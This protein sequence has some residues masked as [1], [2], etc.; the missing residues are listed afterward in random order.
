MA[1]GGSAGQVKRGFR[2]GEVARLTGLTRRQL[3]YWDRTGF[4]R[5]SL[6]P[7]GGRGASR[8]Y[9]FEDIVVLRVVR[10]LL[11]AGMKVR[12]LRQCV[13]Y[14]RCN[15]AGEG[16]AAVCLLFLGGKPLLVPRGSTY[17]VDVLR[18]GQLVWMLDLQGV[19][20]ELAT[21]AGL[22]LTSMTRI[23]GNG[24]GDELL[25]SRG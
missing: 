7:A 23:V 17:A 5:P 9:S 8:V 20:E 14:L 25:G 11:D 15:L 12:G 22:K 21:E 1:S 18:K 4:F 24:K 6:V 10:C 13:E 16:L 2:T 3:D 19:V